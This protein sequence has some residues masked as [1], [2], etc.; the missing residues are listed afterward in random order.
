MSVAFAELLQGSPVFLNV[1]VAEFG[2]SLSE[3]GFSVV[4]V[5]WSPPAGGDLRVAE[6]LDEL[7]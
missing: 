4:Y 6:L 1:G 3:A 5:D 7:L 2:D